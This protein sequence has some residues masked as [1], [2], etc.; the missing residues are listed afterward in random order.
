M[1]PEASVGAGLGINLIVVT[2]VYT[3]PALTDV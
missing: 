1:M 2:N 3:K